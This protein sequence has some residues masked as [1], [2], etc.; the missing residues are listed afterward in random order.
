[1]ALG[2]QQESAISRAGGNGTFVLQLLHARIQCRD[3]LV[4]GRFRL[5]P[6]IRDAAGGAFD[7]SVAS[8]NQEA[9]VFDELLEFCHVGHA[10]TGLR[11]IINAREGNGLEA[12]FREQR[13]TVPGGPVPH[14]LVGFAMARVTC[15]EPLR[16]EVFQFR[17]QREDMPDA[18]RARRHALLGVLLE[19]DE[20]EVVAAVLCGG[21]F[22]QRRRRANKN[23]RP[24]RQRKRLLRPPAKRQCRARRT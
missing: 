4:H 21:R 6:H 17:R 14:H 12:G 11:P 1:M 9:L 20:V 18:R 23:S 19:L 8:V 16:E 15:F 3:K 5:I 24:R 7:F 22:G 2:F 13:E 10:A